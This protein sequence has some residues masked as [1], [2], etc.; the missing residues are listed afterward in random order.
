MSTRV[1]RDALKPVSLPDGRS[2][3]IH[4]LILNHLHEHN[5]LFSPPNILCFMGVTNLMIF[6][7]DLRPSWIIDFL[8]VCK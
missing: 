6:V 2:A 4:V 7:K 1:R 5:A 3:D 8:Q